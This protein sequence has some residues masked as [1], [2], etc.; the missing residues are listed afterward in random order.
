MLILLFTAA[1]VQAGGRIAGIITLRGSPPDSAKLPVLS[2]LS[3]CGSPVLSEELVI[4]KKGGIKNVVVTLRGPFETRKSYPIPSGGF[5]L[6]QKDCRFQPHVMIVA[7]DQALTVWNS[8]RILHNFH[9]LSRQNPPVSFSQPA[10]VPSLTF[11]FSQPETFEVRCDLHDWMKAWIVVA[12]HPFY[13]VT[14]D[15]G[16]FFLSDVP[17]GEHRLTIWHE[18]LG[19]EMRTIR[20][21]E[22]EE[23]RLEIKRSTP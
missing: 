23:T 19:T 3:V 2:D 5:V 16:R 8:D 13:A 9:T 11:V 17:A 22:G 14:D 10:T 6:D 18:K 15:E 4:S 1:E 12:E 7:K 21:R 20:V